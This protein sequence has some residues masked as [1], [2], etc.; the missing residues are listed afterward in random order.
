MYIY[1]PTICIYACGHLYIYTSTKYVSAIAHGC[2]ACG[3][4]ES[5]KIYTYIYIHICVYICV[6]TYI[7]K[8]I[9]KYSYT[10]TNEYIYINTYT[11]AYIFI[12]IHI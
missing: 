8:H 4:Y 11:C 7:C 9:H 6:Y 12:Y 1:I 2:V 5:M 3:K 10:D